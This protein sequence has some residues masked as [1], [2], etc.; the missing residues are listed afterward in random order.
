[1]TSPLIWS[2]SH[3]PALLVPCPPPGWVVKLP[4]RLPQERARHTGAVPLCLQEHAR[5][6]GVVPDWPLPGLV[7]VTAVVEVGDVVVVPPR[8]RPGRGRRPR[9]RRP[10]RPQPSPSLH[11]TPP[12]PSRQTTPRGSPPRTLNQADLQ[13]RLRMLLQ[14]QEQL[15]QGREIANVTMT[16][17]I[18]T[19]YKKGGR[20][21]V[22]SNSSRFSS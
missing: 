15:A 19:S 14:D 20:P 21:T 10:R 6:A 17:S 3:P 13:R 9:P 7:V 11:W 12:R 4:E 18:V 1:M 2:L 5:H 8:G 22:Q 16:N